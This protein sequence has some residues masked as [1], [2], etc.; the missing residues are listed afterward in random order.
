MEEASLPAGR[1]SS[2]DFAGARI[3]FDDDDGGGAHIII[4]VQRHPC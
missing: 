2:L 3:M 1:I 4:I